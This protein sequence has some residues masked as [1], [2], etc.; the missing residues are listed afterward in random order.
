MNLAQDF[1]HHLVPKIEIKKGERFGMTFG[2]GQYL[3]SPHT[4]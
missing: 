4:L 1:P 3:I 2:A